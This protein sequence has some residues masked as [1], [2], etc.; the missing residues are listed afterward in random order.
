VRPIPMAEA[1]SF[2]AV[3][4]RTA[5]VRWALAL[6][7]LALLVTA[8]LAPRGRSASERLVQPGTSGIVVL[9]LSASISQDTYSRIGATLDELTRSGGR[10]GLV[11]FSD[12]A[13]EALPPG[14]PAAELRPLIRY[15]A[16]ERPRT[17]GFAPTFPPNPWSASFSGG[18]KIS[19]GLD[20]ALSIASQ[21]PLGRRGS[22]LLVSDLADDSNDVSRMTATVLELR[23][24]G[25]PLRVVALNP[26]VD[27]R[28]LFARLLGG[29]QSIVDGRTPQQQAQEHQRLGRP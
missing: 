28:A 23:R 18:T 4:R 2:G 20:L 13:Y 12:V 11:V 15:F 14:T 17:A 6:A 25:I 5:V 26:N 3:A 8:I 24:R 10:F 29:P 16:I 7:L 9:D 19:A 1:A 21:R 22:V 27:D